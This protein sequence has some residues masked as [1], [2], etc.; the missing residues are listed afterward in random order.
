M[1]LTKAELFWL[2]NI[3]KNINSSLFKSNQERRS[4]KLY[5]AKAIILS[6]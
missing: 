5:L 6:R 4:F 2:Y 3:Y 1:K